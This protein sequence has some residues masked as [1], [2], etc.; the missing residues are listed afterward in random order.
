VALDRTHTRFFKVTVGDVEELTDLIQPATRGGKFHGD[1]ADAPGWSEHDYHNRIREERHR[2]AAAVS[3]EIS[4]LLAQ[5]DWL[6]VVL[7]GPARVTADQVRFLPRHLQGRVLQSV[8][9]NPTAIGEREIRQIGVTARD[10]ARGQ[11][12]RAHLEEYEEALGSGWAV[13]GTRAALRAIGNGE[14]RVLLVGAGL[15]GLAY[16]CAGS[17]RLAVTAGDCRGEGEPVPVLDIADE[18]I[19]EAIG[20]RVEVVLVDD[21]AAARKLDGLGAVL[22]FRSPRGG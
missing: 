8:R 21:P 11:R 5:G 16:R 12:V 3:D 13:S 18:V 9:L 7:G 22:R 19:E 20:Q 17:G 2:H 4:R 10:V 15:S 1:R 6:G 14:A